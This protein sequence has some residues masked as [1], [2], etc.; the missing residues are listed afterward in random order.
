MTASLLVFVK[1]PLPGLVKTRLAA[2][3]GADAAAD[4]YRALAERVLSQTAPAAG[5]Y[6]RVVFA[7]GLAAV[8]AW[9]PREDCVPQSAGDL[10][11]RMAQ[12]FAWAFARGHERV[13][14]IGTD[15]PE[16]SRRHVQE[17]F[18]AL[19][20][21]D[22]VL[23]PARDG[24]YYLIA[25]RGPCPELFTGIAWSTADV[26]DATLVRAAALGLDG[27]RLSPLTDIDT[28]ED[29]R[30]EWPRLREWLPPALVARLAPALA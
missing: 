14:L 27:E 6:A 26:L 7:D 8:R 12:A 1:P 17:A 22:V 20:T 4:L 13:V 16:L 11:R 24:G 5:E 21:H 29:V 18:A 28:L 2:G 19:A 25:L 15:A 9:L 23:G 3:L 10:G 30:G